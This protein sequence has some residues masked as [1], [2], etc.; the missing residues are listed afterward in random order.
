LGSTEFATASRRVPSARVPRGSLA[1]WVAPY[2]QSTSA[3]VGTAATDRTDA[4]ALSRWDL[5]GAAGVRALSAPYDPQLRVCIGAPRARSPCAEVGPRFRRE[6]GP[7]LW[8]YPWSSCRRQSWPLRTAT[9]PAP[10][11]VRSV[12][13]DAR[14]DARIVMGRPR[15]VATRIRSPAATS[16]AARSARASSAARRSWARSGAVAGDPRPAHW[17]PPT[18]S[19]SPRRP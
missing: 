17:R 13:L 14:D 3:Q 11:R 6:Q 7:R 10:G 9:I 5:V 4:R 19:R 8:G 12:K 16:A 15:P 18:G 1:C 2:C